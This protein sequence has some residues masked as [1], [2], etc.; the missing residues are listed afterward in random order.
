MHVRLCMCLRTCARVASKLSAPKASALSAELASRSPGDDVA[1]LSLKKS[2]PSDTIAYIMDIE[3]DSFKISLNAKQ[4]HRFDFTVPDDAVRTSNSLGFAR[5]WRQQCFLN[6]DRNERKRKLVEM[7][8]E[9]G[10]S[11]SRAP[12]KRAFLIVEVSN[13]TNQRFDPPNWELTM[14]DLEDGLVQAGVLEDDSSSVIVGT[15]FRALET[16]DRD[17][18]H[19]NLVFYELED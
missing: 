5:S 14:K 9:A 16:K 11:W 15:L 6:H 7:G 4:E 19:V 17:A 18:A 10:S 3:L 1:K 2:T 13:K 8:R 12:M